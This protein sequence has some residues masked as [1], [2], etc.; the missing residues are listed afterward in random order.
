[1]KVTYDKYQEVPHPVVSI[2]NLSYL[3]RDSLGAEFTEIEWDLTGL[4]HLRRT[5]L[6]KEN[7]VS[8]FVVPD[9]VNK[10]VVGSEFI[11]VL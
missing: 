6:A 4:C 9:E 7:D 2:I 11:L 10:W 8:R 1:M 5:E 3:E